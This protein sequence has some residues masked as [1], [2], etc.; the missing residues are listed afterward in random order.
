ML[1]ENNQTGEEAQ[2]PEKLE[3][4]AQNY[5]QADDSYRYY[6]ILYTEDY[7]GAGF[8][9]EEAQVETEDA[10]GV[11]YLIGTGCEIFEAVQARDR[12]MLDIV[13][14]YQ[15]KE[16]GEPKKLTLLELGSGRGGLTRFMAQ[17]LLKR[18][19]LNSIMAAN[20]AERENMY[21]LE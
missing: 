21:N 1:G 8:F 17:E 16:E 15:S 5:Y 13:L 12:K 10:P 9:P 4:D 19:M 20:I 11:K 2:L 7:S 6:S 3:N 18:N 14:K